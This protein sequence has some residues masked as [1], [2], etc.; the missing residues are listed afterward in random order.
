[1]NNRELAAILMRE[2]KRA[3]PSQLQ[4]YA[5]ILLCIACTKLTHVTETTRGVLTLPPVSFP[6]P[7]IRYYARA[8]DT[9]G[10]VRADTDM[11]RFVEKGRIRLTYY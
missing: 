10:H 5:R 7:Q 8:T 11:H 3:C 6:P 2:W 4:A 9:R 1:M